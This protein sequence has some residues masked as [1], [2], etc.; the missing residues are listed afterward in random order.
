MRIRIGAARSMLSVSICCR[1]EVRTVPVLTAVFGA[2]TMLEQ[3][4]RPATMSATKQVF[5]KTDAS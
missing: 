3:P 4:L 1:V 2:Y 5:A